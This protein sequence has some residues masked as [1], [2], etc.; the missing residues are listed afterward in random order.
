MV[1]EVFTPDSEEVAEARDAGRAG[2]TPRLA[3]GAGVFT[4][5]DGRMVD[6]AVVRHARRLLDFAR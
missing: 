2:S 1:N 3:A 5:D 6:L 4:D